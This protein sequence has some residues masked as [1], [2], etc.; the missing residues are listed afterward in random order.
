MPRHKKENY[1]R[2]ISPD[3]VYGSPLVEKFINVVMWRGKKSVARAIVYDALADLGKR[4]Q[5][6]KAQTL[7]LFVKAFTRLIPTVEVRSRR[8]GGNVYQIPTLV[9]G[10]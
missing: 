2:P 10:S 8:V 6:D 7:D 4:N 9:N 5:A 1:V 3:P